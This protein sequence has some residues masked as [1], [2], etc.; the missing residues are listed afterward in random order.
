M[1]YITKYFYGPQIWCDPRSGMLLRSCKYISWLPPVT[2]SCD[3]CPQHT[4]VLLLVISCCCVHDL[5]CIS[6][7][8]RSCHSSLL[9]W[10]AVDTVCCD[11]RSQHTEV[12]LLV[13]WSLTIGY[14]WLL[15]RD[16][17]C[18]RLWSVQR[19]SNL[20]SWSAGATVCWDTWS[21][22]TEASLLFINPCY[23]MVPVLQLLLWLRFAVLW[24]HGY[25]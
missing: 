9:S 8:P 3:T 4:E 18:S 13:I 19:N 14:R 22:H 2:V 11:A 16:L 7:W 10:S 20:L 25:W 21:Q 12:S 17:S 23:C 6:L 5:G 15:L 24:V 1:P